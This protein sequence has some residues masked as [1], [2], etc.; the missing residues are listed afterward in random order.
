[1][2]A[3]YLEDVKREFRSLKRLAEK[4]M[5]QVS[6]EDFFA[7]LDPNS[8]S[9]ALLVKHI[10]GNLR[11]RWTDFLTSDG[12]KPDRKRDTEF[13]GRPEDTRA[14]LLGRW[15]AGWQVLFDALGDLAPEDLSRE[16]TIRG[17]PH[18][19]MRA[20]HRQMTHY[21]EHIGQIVMLAKH[22]AGDRWQTLSIPRGQSEQFARQMPRTPRPE[23]GPSR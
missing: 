22:W 17:Q 6:D 4:A 14:S 11:S 2:L 23:G 18:S 5:A 3:Y 15:E 9:I 16:V 12:E 20:I 10:S 19:V 8:N 13:E 21:A 7:T 1:L